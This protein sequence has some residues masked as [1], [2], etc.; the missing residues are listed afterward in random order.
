MKK[1]A[2][3]RIVVIL[4]AVGVGAIFWFGFLGSNRYPTST[5]R[6]I[7]RRGVTFNRDVAPIIF[8][9]CSGCHRPGQ[10]APFSLLQ[11]SEIRKRGEQI[12]EVTAKRIM[13]P[14]LPES[15]PGEFAN[16]RQLSPDE[17]QIVQQ[18]VADGC[19]EGNAAD[20]P[21]L[22]SWPDGWQLG[23]PDLVV[24]MPQA[25]TLEAGGPDVY[26]NFTIPV[27]V[28]NTRFV[29]A[30]EFRPGNPKIV[31]HTFIKMDRS[32]E[33]RRLDEQDPEPGFSFMLTPS[34]AQ[35]PEGHFLSWTPGQLPAPEPE[36]QSWTLAAGTDLVLQLHLRR[37]G[38]RET[39]QSEL[40][41]YFTNRPPARTPLKI[42]LTSRALEIP[43]GARDYTV[44]DEL[45][46]P[47]DVELLSILPHA[48]YLGR[49][50]QSWAALP[51]G[52]T[53]S[54]LRIRQW[55]FN[56][57]SDYRYAKPV[58]LPKGAAISMRFSYDNS[59][60]NVRNPHQPPERVGYGPQTTD[61][62]AELWFQVLPRAPGDLPLLTRALQNHVLHVWRAQYELTLRSNP[63]D[64]RAHSQLGQTLLGMGDLS[65]AASHLRRA[66]ELKPD[67]DEP[68][69]YLGYILRAQR[70]LAAA[71]F[72]Y[73][74]VIRLNPTNH[75]AYGNLGLVRMEQRKFSE[76]ENAFSSAL[77]I[78]PRDDVARRNLQAVREA[79]ANSK[80]K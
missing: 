67:F 34:G 32:G 46:L 18:W 60:N 58:L 45:R 24:Q 57:Q 22:P 33:S 37:S 38:K 40:G 62:M 50:M 25:Y 19:V 55:D 53:R 64:A 75:E 44:H 23:R 65:G 2:K 13:P 77:A 4:A 72:E 69:F 66:I 7:P 52:T 80:A 21:P 27:P 47:C 8:R 29:R 74:E 36:G 6:P 68:H 9:N 15:A 73:S 56:W 39:I 3:Q 48:H 76:A 11:Y 79:V 30:V 51:D 12:G 41:L 16:D 14:W 49:E 35:M 43:A 31:H 17:I 78:N 28:A 20:L 42:L 63:N 26:R 71:E 70:N 59:T 5:S 61:E 54:L 1:P 10:A